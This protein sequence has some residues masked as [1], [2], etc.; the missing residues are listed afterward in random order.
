MK[1]II[2]SVIQFQWIIEPQNVLC[3]YTNVSFMLAKTKEFL[4]W[5]CLYESNKF[6]KDFLL[7]IACSFLAAFTNNT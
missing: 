7:L 3:S 6:T 4:N 1:L 2:F 5:W